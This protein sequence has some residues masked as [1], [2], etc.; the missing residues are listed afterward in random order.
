MNGKAIGVFDSG[1]GGLT[2]AGEIIKQLPNENIIYFGDTA[3]FPYGSRSTDEL[4]GFVFEIVEFLQEKG[5]KF[6]VIACNSASAAALE[7]TQ[8]HFSVPMIGVVEPGARAAVQATRN[9]RIGVIGTPATISSSAYVEA[10]HTYDSQA[11]V[12]QQIC[13][14]LADYVERGETRG[15]K[16]KKVIKNY[17][18]P[19]IAAQADTLILGCTHYPLLSATIKEVTGSGIRLISSAEEAA[20]EVKEILKSKGYLREGN[21]PPVYQFISSG[22]ED[23]FLK[24]GSQFLGHPIDKV[25]RVS[26]DRKG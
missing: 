6:I 15:E 1:V 4:K 12:Y 2:V 9:R 23:K 3:R 5:V 18:A 11:E 7:V 25:E 19:I 24:L 16:V 14:D 8:K 10:V 22:D 20:K 13:L 26:L 17:L 21:S